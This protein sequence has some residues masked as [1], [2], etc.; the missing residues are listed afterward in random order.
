LAT[1]AIAA[2]EPL[3]ACGDELP[4]LPQTLGH[5]FPETSQNHSFFASSLL[6]EGLGNYGAA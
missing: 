6:A 2:A 5:S 4:I 3:C 1:F